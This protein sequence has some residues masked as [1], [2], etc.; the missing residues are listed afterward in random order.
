MV[1]FRHAQKPLDSGDLRNVVKTINTLPESYTG[2]VE[3]LVNDSDPFVATRNLAQLLVLGDHPAD[4]L[5]VEG[6]LH[7]WVSAVLPLSHSAI[8]NYSFYPVRKEGGSRL[9]FGDTNSSVDIGLS[10]DANRRHEEWFPGFEP[11]HDY[12]TGSESKV[13][14][15]M[16]SI[17]RSA[18][19][20]EAMTVDDQDRVYAQVAPPHRV[21]LKKFQETGVVLPF[22]SARNPIMGPNLYLFNLTDSSWAPPRGTNPL[23]GW[24]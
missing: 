2:K 17:V 23:H 21:A 18:T 11:C 20:K 9:T 16:A 7:Y 6:V 12:L 4:D 3:V 19:I 22:G 10:H 8:H 5:A 1:G 15:V 24:E 13:L 14:D